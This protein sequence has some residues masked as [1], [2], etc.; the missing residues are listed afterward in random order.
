MVEYK[1]NN[2]YVL[3]NIAEIYFAVNITDKGLYKNKKMYTLNKM[4]FCLLKI[5][6]NLCRFTETI[7]ADEILKILIVQVDKKMVYA[8]VS[9]FCKDVY[10]KGI[11]KK[12]EE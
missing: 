3:R 1:F 7:L 9:A 6:Q 8:D 10:T 12:Y 11:L 4:G 5:A 2:E